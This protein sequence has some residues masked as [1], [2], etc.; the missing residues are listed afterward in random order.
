ML[1]A[2]QPPPDHED[3]A[4]ATGLTLGDLD[5]FVEEA[6][7]RWRESASI[8]DSGLDLLA[9]ASFSIAD[10][11]GS[12]AGPDERICVQI[13]ADAAGHGWFVDSSPH[14]DQEFE[15][16]FG[17]TLLA[18]YRS[19][20]A[21]RMDL[22]TVVMHEL[23]HVA[24]FE[25]TAQTGLMAETLQ[26]SQRHLPASRNAGPDAASAAD[27]LVETLRA[28]EPPP[29]DGLFLTI[30]PDPTGADLSLLRQGLPEFFGGL[31]VRLNISVF[32]SATTYVGLPLIG[33]QMATE[34]PGQFADLLASRLSDFLAGIDNVSV[35]SV[36]AELERTL[37]GSIAGDI[38]V[39][40]RDGDP[41]IL[42]QLTLTGTISDAVDAD[43]GLGE[44]PFLEVL[45]NTEDMAQV[46]ATWSL[47]VT[48]GVIETS[49]GSF[50]VVDTSQA[51]EVAVEVQVILDSDLS[52]IGKL[53]VFS[54]LIEND[55]NQVSTFQGSY[56]IDLVDPDNH[57]T[58]AELDSLVLD[59]SLSGTGY[60]D[61]DIEGSFVP[62]LYAWTDGQY[63]G[64]TDADRNDVFNV[65]IT[66][67]AKI[68]YAFADADPSSATFGT[69]P[70][71]AFDNVQLDADEYLGG[72]LG[73]VIRALRPVLSQIKPILDFLQTPIPGISDLSEAVGGPP[74]TFMDMASIGSPAASA[75]LRTLSL[76]TT[77]VTAEAPARTGTLTNLV[78]MGSFRVRAS[79]VFGQKTEVT[80][81]KPA[82]DAKKGVQSKNELVMKLGGD[83]SLPLLEDP[84]NIF[85]LMR[86]ETDVTMLG[87]RIDLDLQLKFAKTIPVFWI[88][89]VKIEAKFGMLLD[90]DMGYDTLGI[91]W[92]SETLDYSDLSTLEA[93]LLGNKQLLR[94]GLYFDDHNSKGAVDGN[95]SPPAFT[96]S[97]ELAEDP[98]NLDGAE[99]K[100]F[101]SVGAGVVLGIDTGVI[102][103]NVGVDFPFTLDILFDL[104]DLPN[105]LPPD[106]WRD[107]AL[108]PG[109]LYQYPASPADY[110]YDGR[111]RLGELDMEL[112]SDRLAIFKSMGEFSVALQAYILGTLDFGFFKIVVVDKRWNLY[113]MTLANFDI[114]TPPS[115]TEV[116][117]GVVKRPPV[118]AG[119]LDP[120]D[121]GTLTLYMGPYDYLREN[122]NPN[123]LGRDYGLDEEFRIRSLGPTDPNDPDAGETVVVKYLDTFEQEFTGVKKIVGNG[124]SGDDVFYADETVGVDVVMVGGDGA[125]ALVYRGSGD[126]TLWGDAGD[127]VLAGGGGNDT[128]VGGDGK[129][130]IDGQAGDDLLIGGN[131]ILD[132][133]AGVIP[134][135][136]DDAVDG[137]MLLGGPGADVLYGQGGED[138]LDG[139]DGDDV[140]VGGAG[141]DRYIWRP[142]S[143][144]DTFVE[145]PGLADSDQLTVEGGLELVG[146]GE[147]VENYY[148]RELDDDITLS[149]AGAAVIINDGSSSI[150]AEN[151]EQIVVAA[152]GGADTVTIGD[153]SGTRLERLAIDLSSP[154]ETAPEGDKVV[155]N[156]SADP[157]V[158]DVI[159]VDGVYEQHDQ[160]NLETGETGPGSSPAVR[161][162]DAQLSGA[163]SSQPWEAFIINSSPDRDQLEIYGNQ[164]DD[165]LSITAGQE[166]V[167]VHDLID[168]SL[169]GGEGSDTIRSV[170]ADVRI[171]G[172][173]G[174]DFVTLAD[175]EYGRDLPSAMRF[176]ELQSDVLEYGEDGLLLTGSSILAAS[177]EVSRSVYPSD[178]VSELFTLRMADGGAFD[179][180]ALDVRLRDADTAG[181]TVMFTGTTASG[182]TVTQSFYVDSDGAAPE[183]HTLLFGA[184]FA[185]LVSVSWRP[186]MTVTDNIV[187]NGPRLTLSRAG[188]DSGAFVAAR[189]GL[190]DT[191][192]WFAGI[193]EMRLEMGCDAAGNHLQVLSS[194]DGPLTVD[195]GAG[196][197]ALFIGSTQGPLVVNLEGGNNEVSFGKDGTL[198]A[199]F[200][201]AHVNGGPGEDTIV[202]DSTGEVS[203]QGHVGSD[204]VLGLAAP[205]V[206]G[207]DANVESLCLLLGPGDDT[208]WVPDPGRNIV[209]R[210]GEGE[211]TLVLDLAADPV[212]GKVTT[213]DVE[214]IRVSDVRAAGAGVWT[215]TD[216]PA[217]TGQPVA[218]TS[219]WALDGA[220]LLQTFDA[221]SS[222]L[223]LT[224]RADTV[225]ILDVNH[226]TSVDLKQGDDEVRV[227]LPQQSLYKN[228]DDILSRL[229]LLGGDG[230]DRLR[231]ADTESGSERQIGVLGVSS[232]AGFGM[233]LEARIEHYGFEELAIEALDDSGYDVT[234]LENAISATITL[235]AGD[236]TVSVGTSSGPLSLNL[237]EGDD[238]VDLHAAAALL[239]IDGGG[240]DGDRLV[241]DGTA[242]ASPLSGTLSDGDGPL[243]LLA[244]TGLVSAASFQGM[245][246]VDVRLGSGSDAFLVD[247]AGAGPVLNV[248]GYGG[249]DKLTILDCGLAADFVG[250]SG[251]DTLE[252]EIPGDP[253]LE[254]F[255]GLTFV[256][257]TLVI[258]NSSY[259]SGVDWTLEAGVLSAGGNAVVK[260]DGADE[261]RIIGGL[262]TDT[263]AV[264]ET[265]GPVDASISGNRVK[266]IQ[267]AVVLEPEDF[268]HDDRLTTAGG[269]EGL[270][271]PEGL[272][273]VPDPNGSFVYVRDADGTLSVFREG[274]AGLELLQVLP[275]SSDGL[276]GGV[277]NTSDL[278]VTPDLRFLYTSTGALSQIGVF[279]RDAVTGLLT[280]AA[281]FKDSENGLDGLGGVS[282]LAI[283]GDGA[284]V[285]S[286]ATGEGAVG[287]FDVLA[288]GSLTLRQV[289]WG[290]AGVDR[291]AIAD[292]GCRAY[293]AA[294]H[295]VIAYLRDT[296]TGT[297]TWM[298]RIGPDGTIVRD[299]TSAG[300]GDAEPNDQAAFALDLES[301]FASDTSSWSQSWSAYIPGQRYASWS[302]TFAAEAGATVRL[303][304]S[305]RLSAYSATAT[306]EIRLAGKT[307]TSLI[308]SSLLQYECPTSGTYEI[309]LINWAYF[310][311]PM[312]GTLTATVS[313]L[314]ASRSATAEGEI[315]GTQDA[316]FYRFQAS[317][318]DVVT[319]TADAQNVTLPNPA[320]QVFGYDELDNT[321]V[322]L[323]FALVNGSL[324]YTAMPYSGDYYLVVEASGSQTGTY[325]FTVQHSF[326][327]IRSESETGA[328]NTNDTAA[329]ADD[330]T[331]S[332]RPGA[333]DVYTALIGGSLDP[334]DLTQ[335]DRRSDRA[336]TNLTVVPGPR[337]HP[338]GQSALGRHSA[339]RRRRLR[340]R[341]QPS[342]QL[343]PAIQGTGH[344]VLPGSRLSLHPRR[345]LSLSGGL[346]SRLHQL[347]QSRS[348]VAA[349]L[350]EPRS[351]PQR[352]RALPDNGHRHRRFLPVKGG[353]AD[354]PR[355]RL[356]LAQRTE[357]DIRAGHSF[358]VRPRPGHLADGVRHL[359]HH[360][361]GR[362]SH[363][364]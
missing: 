116:L 287:V 40:G 38:S 260:T 29:A 337:R 78:G 151:M 39:Y 230:S 207:F 112:A 253:V 290:Q 327:G 101:A 239:S 59:A 348:Q 53:G 98:P 255:T 9:S 344:A 252:I 50:F 286:A 302:T 259:G 82:T 270:A 104:N 336:R 363:L 240:G 285:Y 31:Q 288:N 73:P 136:A 198:A 125:D 111:V 182:G 163:G 360:H 276:G 304:N 6:R 301:I 126:A 227:G 258:D 84:Q 72:F 92:L 44:D 27:E 154:V 15:L 141:A 103:I 54:A 187:A 200:G 181:Q 160:T 223:S 205:A 299:L 210:G 107:P 246:E 161:I 306:M 350:V 121:P 291:I 201:S 353:R 94:E 293:A 48:F 35:D 127:D 197:D 148:Y 110:T 235:G 322:E 272:A 19:A 10:L 242:S 332:F 134:D 256:T 309:V 232:I 169:Y 314:A 89:S 340:A 194:I 248:S 192:A 168:V 51:D 97:G 345:G 1:E 215:L 341:V 93:S 237:G 118:F 139:G 55:P 85:K 254:D 173:A 114:Y 43:L 56:T 140:L 162:T 57:L 316:D 79:K 32:N 158:V 247:H 199:I 228:L 271:G 238:E 105:R 269:I 196:N 36:V 109:V 128:L 119:F 326:P 86:G 76:I 277:G 34:T 175:D 347:S 280:Y 37:A 165:R 25:H 343:F 266:L 5:S 70:V 357:Q 115:D 264:V 313:P 167:R 122:T 185:D 62:D 60:A 225:E 4:A 91:R 245:E 221:A 33:T 186:L 217:G 7:R 214:T 18:D 355:R 164:G 143:G 319:L 250:G 263:L 17:D 23:G 77:L 191:V 129:D 42:F 13:D 224:Y 220:P 16:V 147:D 90:F 292:D 195:D 233:P 321:W 99:L 190:P 354:G 176:D 241:F 66:T 58:V 335:P 61:L 310:M 145:A 289:L 159:T 267:G 120:A 47:E 218:N 69:D 150:S 80:E 328:T 131:A 358:P 236:D 251:N 96:V 177:A 153:L 324:R 317:P 26:A 124:G 64:L 171:D 180:D 303:D 323:P 178:P 279:S 88:L 75:A 113:K 28:G 203:V 206:V 334:V 68:T 281:T 312:S 297:L 209:I 204:E 211:D 81:S 156:G 216:V 226:D 130:D 308:N 295:D 117:S 296:S 275:A 330:L 149:S 135:P 46:T 329:R 320:L 22:L 174:T 14:D 243:G 20:A 52:A 208:L 24:G 315:S 146:S 3:S 144:A 268:A 133:V 359:L 234:I 155:I 351:D 123:G 179:L 311:G 307:L 305:V 342:R 108:E 202:F 137:D 213:F 325:R 193:E 172:G 229:I 262:G 102:K 283:S 352:G 362:I 152:G 170:Y 184:G 95:I 349:L 282:G 219:L 361:A 2:A 231:L 8:D 261:V 294:G 65:A 106:Q 339:A 318:G 30:T 249:D 298:Y 278:V 338:V 212:T 331:G 71:I 63:Q 333:G 273:V 166:D 157:A 222:L 83:I 21:G 132:V 244:I 100:F 183:F 87:L 67:D 300:G 45:I 189:R 188:S 142:G 274:P 12:G 11:D 346:R 41:L 265:G 284:F 74:V 257:E 356:H 364:R 49:D 138:Y